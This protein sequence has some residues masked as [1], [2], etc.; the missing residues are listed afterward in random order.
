MMGTIIMVFYIRVDYSYY[1]DA[2]DATSSVDNTNVINI[3][4]HVQY[5]TYIHSAE[6]WGLIEKSVRTSIYFN[7][8]NLNRN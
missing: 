5:I 2:R 4:M 6:V 7:R 8:F 1:D 3:S